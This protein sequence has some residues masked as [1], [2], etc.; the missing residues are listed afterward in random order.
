MQ[1]AAINTHWEIQ[2]DYIHVAFQEGERAVL[3]FADIQAPATL[4]GSDVSGHGSPSSTKSALNWETFL[5]SLL[6]ALVK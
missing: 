3:V 6:A 4:P 5:N 2:Q 1:G